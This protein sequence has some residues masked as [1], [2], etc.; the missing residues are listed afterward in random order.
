MP[1]HDET[2]PSLASLR[3]KGRRK[4]TAAPSSS[5]PQLGLSF[6]PQEPA[7]P[8][9][10]SLRKPAPV[11]GAPAAVQPAAPPPA[12]GM[13]AAPVA[14]R[15]IWSVRDLVL[16]V[17]QQVERVYGDLWLEGEISNCRRAPSGHI[18]LTLKDGEAQ[19]PVVLFRRSAA[20]LRFRPAD[21]LAVL[22]RGRISVYEA[23]GQ[24][25]LIAET[26]E[27]RGAGALQLAFEQRKA[28]LLAEGLFDADR[29]R[30]LPTFPRTVGLITSP[31]GAVIRDIVTVVR[32]R[33]AGL[34]LLVY[35]ALMQGPQCAPSVMAGLHWFASHPTAV[36]LI[37][38]ARGGGSMEDLA[39]FNDE[40]LAR[41]IAASPL[42][43]VSAIGHETDFT[44]ADFVADLRAPTPSAA[45]EII[46]AGQ[47]RI[48]ER[49]DALERRAQRALRLQLMEAR[50]RYAELAAPAVLLRLRDSISRRDQYLDELHL[51]LDSAVAR[52][53]RRMSQR[54]AALQARLARQDV[55]LRLAAARM[56]L[57]RAEQRLR[58]AARQ[59]P[60]PARARLERVTARLQALSPLAVL[61][62]GYALVYAESSTG[63]AGSL[64]HAAEQVA[65][66]DSLRV[67]L[68]SGELRATVTA[69]EPATPATKS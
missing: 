28:R 58:Y 69:V 6:Q 31:T 68:G 34:N 33:H 18:Y 63:A 61:A 11:A 2:L 55:A 1:E 43:V 7:A 29:K 20:L 51:R 50:Q 13:E 65:A 32:R 47:H 3:A 26:M 60:P 19:L 41:A 25:Q 21:G 56:R 9:R 62:R 8:A 66:G 52:R 15:R 16:E 45:A 30:P 37:V 10:P 5:A 54:L 42:P 4:R 46:T 48:E 39:G 14:E 49:V 17:R 27:P 67:R 44:I 24:L 57:Q 35:P 53:L 36:D 23:R 40:A 59:L 64:L 38:L 22:V 12:Q